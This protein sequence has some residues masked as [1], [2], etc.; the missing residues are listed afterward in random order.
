MIVVLWAFL[1]MFAQDILGTVM[2]QAEAR[3]QANLSALLDTVGWGASFACTYI[4]ITALQ[5][6]N[7]ALKVFVVAAISAAN[8][9]GTWT[10]VIIGKRW[11][12]TRTTIADTRATGSS[13]S[14]SLCPCQLAPPSKGES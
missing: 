12:K 10:G 9:G 8:Y 6:H 11:V 5:G 4:G 1:A 14:H 7:T 2:V 3:N 13:K